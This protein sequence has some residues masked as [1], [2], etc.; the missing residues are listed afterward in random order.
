MHCERT[1][2]SNLESHLPMWAQYQW[3]SVEIQTSR[4]LIARSR[5][6]IYW[7]AICCKCMNITYYSS[8]DIQQEEKPCSAATR[9]PLEML[10]LPNPWKA[11]LRLHINR[12]IAMLLPSA[13]LV[14]EILI[15]LSH[16][17][18]C[19]FTRFILQAC[20]R[21]WTN[22]RNA[23]LHHDSRVHHWLAPRASHGHQAGLEDVLDSTR[24]WLS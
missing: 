10:S 23:R 1:P 5:E 18:V 2:I 16:L 21:L 9:R 6:S 19:T 22:A 15:P 4:G 3:A 24:Y 7:V 14:L 13:L 17:F 20:T 8:R 11:V 12:C